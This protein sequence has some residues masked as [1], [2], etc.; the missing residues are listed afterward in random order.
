[1]RKGD[2]GGKGGKKIKLKKVAT[3]VIAN[4]PPNDDQLQPDRLCHYTD[5]W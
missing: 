4:R 5:S 3:N 1:M 2:N